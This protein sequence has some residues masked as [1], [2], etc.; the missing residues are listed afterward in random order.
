VPLNCF[1]LWALGACSSLW[2]ALPH[3]LPRLTPPHPLEFCS[4]AQPDPSGLPFLSNFHGELT[5]SC[6]NYSGVKAAPGQEQ[7]H[8]PP[9]ICRAWQ[10]AACKQLL[11]CRLP[12]LWLSQLASVTLG[13]SFYP[14]SFSC[15]NYETETIQIHWCRYKLTKKFVEDWF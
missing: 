3:L 13:R 6:G 8:Q 14:L 4:E 7:A 12:S 9:K 1:C 10:K 5:T 2:Q 11:K 15:P